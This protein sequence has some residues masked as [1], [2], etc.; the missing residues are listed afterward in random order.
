MFY[1]IFVYFIF[2]TIFQENGGEN[3]VKSE[4]ESPVDKKKK[5]R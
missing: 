5:K 3:G 1:T 2:H 4:G